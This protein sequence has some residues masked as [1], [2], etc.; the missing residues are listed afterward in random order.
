MADNRVGYSGGN[1]NVST[2][3][4][5]MQVAPGSFDQI[6]ALL[7]PLMAY[8]QQKMQMD[9]AAQQQAME[10]A[11][12]D[13]A[14]RAQQQQQATADMRSAR[15]GRQS[16]GEQA[17][18]LGPQQWGG[19]G[20]EDLVPE[21]ASIGK[22]GYFGQTGVPN[23]G[24][25]TAAT[26]RMIPRSQAAGPGASSFGYA[27]TPSAAGLQ[28]ST[29]GAT[30]GYFSAPGSQGQSMAERNPIRGEEPEQP[31]KQQSGRR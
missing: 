6:G 19:G 30:G 17:M 7:A 15:V 12:Q 9:L 4:P 3:A 14:L 31:E 5:G 10:F 20:G 11:R 18:A 26:G 13:Q 24:A 23:M 27:G 1:M 28:A 29:L 8:K 16:S 21:M 25:S 2:S 22:Y